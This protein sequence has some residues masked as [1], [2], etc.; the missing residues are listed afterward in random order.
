[1][2]KGSYLSLPGPGG[3]VLR[4]DVVL[5]N[6]ASGETA[7]TASDTSASNRLFSLA[8]TSALPARPEAS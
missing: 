2:V 6:T 5:Q 4:L 3:E 8:A 1:V 7:G